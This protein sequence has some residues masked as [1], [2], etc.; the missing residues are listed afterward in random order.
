MN[1]DVLFE[2]LLDL[3]LP[4]LQVRVGNRLRAIDTNA[5]R[6]RLLVLVRERNQT[7]IAQHGVAV[8]WSGK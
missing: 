2:A 8:D 5:Q 7:L 1:P 6:Q 4:G 3:R